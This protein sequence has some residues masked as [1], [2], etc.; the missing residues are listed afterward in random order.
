ML[1]TPEGGRRG[2]GER[3]SNVIGWALGVQYYTPR[4]AGGMQYHITSR[5]GPGGVIYICVGGAV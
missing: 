4:P 3:R 5:G 2:G 1:I